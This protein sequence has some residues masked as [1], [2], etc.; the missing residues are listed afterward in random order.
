M[1]KPAVG[2]EDLSHT[3]VIIFHEM[4]LLYMKPRCGFYES[5]LNA[6]RHVQFLG[7][8]AKMMTATV[9]IFIRLKSDRCSSPCEDRPISCPDM[10]HYF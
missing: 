5:A 3:E 9:K 2:H 7:K 1:Q 8:R 6:S 4:K 10:Q